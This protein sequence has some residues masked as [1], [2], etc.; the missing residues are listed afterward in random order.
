MKTTTKNKLYEGMFLVDSAQAGADWDGIIAAIKTILERTEAEIV[1][2]RK[3]DDRRLA[4]GINGKTRGT[5]ILC[6]FKADGEKIQ[7][8]EKN[9]QLSEQ[10]MRVLILS[11]EQLTA[12]DVEKDTPATKVE[13]EREKRKTAKEATQKTE[14]K[15]VS[16][17][18]QMQEAEQE[19]TED[20]QESEP[21][22]A[23]DDSME[24]LA[25]AEP[26]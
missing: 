9:V 13:K 7:D 23:G 2:I 17:Q 22:M 15:Q 10:I 3:W 16:A 11:A 4:Y 5:Y 14:A 24:K 19:E 21:S 26:E 12:E 20:S 8:I 1:S 18:E 6:Y 25:G